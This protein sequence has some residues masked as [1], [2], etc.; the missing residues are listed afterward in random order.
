MGIGQALVLGRP[1]FIRL[2]RMPLVFLLYTL[3]RAG[4]A[5]VM[6]HHK[7]SCTYSK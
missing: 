3:N 7:L 2:L 5:L 1:I 6:V 4:P